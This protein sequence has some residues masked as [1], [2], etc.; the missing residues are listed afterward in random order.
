LIACQKNPSFMSNFPI[1]MTFS[2]RDTSRRI[3]DLVSPQCVRFKRQDRAG[4]DCA[5]PSYLGLP[6]KYTNQLAHANGIFGQSKP[7][8][9][10]QIW[11]EHVANLQQ[12]WS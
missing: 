4:R 9:V 8:I 7:Q 1:Q 12:E 5:D 2:S 10:A 3:E 6:V 11:F